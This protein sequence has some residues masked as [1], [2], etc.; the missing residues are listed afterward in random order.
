MSA[1]S[2]ETAGTERSA[3]GI[4]PRPVVAFDMDGTLTWTDT[5]T[6]FLR[7]FAGRAGFWRAMARLAP[8][9]GRYLAA[10]RDRSRLKSAVARRFLAG[11]RLRDVE[12]AGEEAAARHMQTLLRADAAAA[13]KRHQDN[14]ARVVI[15]TA[16]PDFVAGPIAR[17]LG[18]ERLATRFALEDGRLTGAL[19]GL[20]CRG[21]EKVRRLHAH[22]GSGL[23]LTHAYGDSRGDR[24]LL[25]AA[26]APG[27]R[28]FR[29][30]PAF[31]GLAA[32]RLLA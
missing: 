18:C 11:A 14:G 24:D 22:V 13:L 20:N 5:Y 28:V 31:P 9:G 7:V 4:R 27:Y 1:S 6:V 16:A 23:R 2:G 10:G 30:G 17:R 3:A 32:L 19:T 12:A 15:V 8:A 21:P 26:E 25:A 29:D